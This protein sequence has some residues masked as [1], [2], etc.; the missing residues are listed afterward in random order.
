MSITALEV[1]TET[2]LGLACARRP[3][4]TEPWQL[5][6]NILGKSA[7]GKPLERPGRPHFLPYTELPNN[8]SLAG[9]KV[10]KAGKACRR[11]AKVFLSEL[12]G[13]SANSAI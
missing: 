11:T 7:I 10:K 2:L 3:L 12:C 13:F 6:I 8:V 4:G 1:G 5:Y 9:E